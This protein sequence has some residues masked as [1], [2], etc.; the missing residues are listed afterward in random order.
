MKK[1]LVS[2]EILQSL[3]ISNDIEDII[4]LINHITNIRK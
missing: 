4:E 3:A 2:T 1:H